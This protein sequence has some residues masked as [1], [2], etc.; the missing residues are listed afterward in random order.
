[1]DIYTTEDGKVIDSGV[2]KGKAPVAILKNSLARLGSNTAIRSP[3][4]RSTKLPVT[5]D[6]LEKD[7]ATMG[8]LYSWW[9][10]A[11]ERKHSST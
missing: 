8:G 9:S 11:S 1:M 4:V 10:F 2:G 5:V 7:P 3:G 6:K